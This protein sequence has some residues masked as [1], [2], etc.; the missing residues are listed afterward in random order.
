[1]AAKTIIS[2]RMVELARPGRLL[3]LGARHAASRR[4]VARAFVL[5]KILDSPVHCGLKSGRKQ[6]L[7][8]HP[9]WRAHLLVSFLPSTQDRL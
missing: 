4:R 7:P 6:W 8:W 9:Q 2:L 3:L 5:F 1:V